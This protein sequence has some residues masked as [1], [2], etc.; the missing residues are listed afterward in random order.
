M[1]MPVF[2][3]E[4]LGAPERSSLESLAESRGPGAVAR[5]RRAAA[6]TGARLRRRGLDRGEIARDIALATPDALAEG[7]AD[8]WTSNPCSRLVRAAVRQALEVARR[9]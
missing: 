4:A 6:A 5:L 9:C 8:A 3:A 7:G 2:D 1:K